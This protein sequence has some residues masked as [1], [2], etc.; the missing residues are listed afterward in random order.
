MEKG[1]LFRRG[2]YCGECMFLKTKLSMEKSIPKPCKWFGRI[3]LLL[4][5]YHWF[6]SWVIKGKISWDIHEG[7]RNEK[8]LPC[9]LGQTPHC[10]GV[11][12][13]QQLWCSSQIPGVDPRVLPRTRIVHIPWSLCVFS[14]AKQ[15]PDIIV[16]LCQLRSFGR[17][18]FLFFLIYTYYWL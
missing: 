7:L 3:F 12:G 11:L 2:S 9:F 10:R 16:L 4:P 1:P 14:C 8:T 15:C 13:Q 6:C 18:V 17:C 5:G